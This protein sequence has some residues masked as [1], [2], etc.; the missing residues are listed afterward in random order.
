MVVPPV[1]L[2]YTVDEVAEQ[3]GQSTRWVRARIRSGDI[4]AIWIGDHPFVRRDVFHRLTQV[5]R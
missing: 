4:P 2:T 1:P 5:Q 3:L